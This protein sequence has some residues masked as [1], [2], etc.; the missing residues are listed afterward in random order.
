MHE[1]IYTPLKVERER[2]SQEK[3]T[4]FQGG[5]GLSK[6]KFI[7]HLHSCPRVVT[8]DLELLHHFH[9]VDE[10]SHYMGHG[11]IC[12]WL[13]KKLRHGQGKDFSLI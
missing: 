7:K 2:A 3:N 11:L 4:S 6:C 8:L 5:F 9:G 13:I 12:G 1:D 10:L